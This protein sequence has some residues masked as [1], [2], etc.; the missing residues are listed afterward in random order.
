MSP[1]STSTV[2]DGA[3]CCSRNGQTLERDEAAQVRGVGSLPKRWYRAFSDITAKA[4]LEDKRLGAGIWR[5]ET[6]TM[7]ATRDVLADVLWAQ[8]S[9]QEFW[10]R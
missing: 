2:M 8:S 1:S 4:G 10:E 5:L 3:I 9:L 6:S 7:M